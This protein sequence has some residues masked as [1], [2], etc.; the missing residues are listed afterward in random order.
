MKAN[1]LPTRA[2]LYQVVRMRMNPSEI[3]VASVVEAHG[4]FSSRGQLSTGRPVIM[5]RG[6]THI[7]VKNF[8]FRMG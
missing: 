5:W 2:E 3:T 8:T 1:G 4:T 7:G 6:F